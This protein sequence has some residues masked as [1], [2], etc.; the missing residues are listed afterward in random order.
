MGC[1]FSTHFSFKSP[2]KKYLHFFDAFLRVYTFSTHF[3]KKTLFRR[4]SLSLHFFDAFLRRLHF[5]DAFLQGK[6]KRKSKSFNYLY[7]LKT[8]G[9]KPGNVR[10]REVNKFNEKQ[11]Q[12]GLQEL[13]I[14]YFQGFG[15]INFRFLEKKVNY[16]DTCTQGT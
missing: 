5:F 12:S 10:D 1:T 14:F 16:S 6:I 4:I 2:K 8:S 3:S 9:Y 11:E 7:L 15:F 13:G